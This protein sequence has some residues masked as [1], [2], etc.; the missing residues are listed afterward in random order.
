MTS[1]V[2]AP[3]PATLYRRGMMAT[4]MTLTTERNRPVGEQLRAWRERRRLSQMALALDAEVS[5]RHLS[6]LETGK[7]RPSR[8]ML[9]RLAEHLAVPLRDRNALLLAAG[10]APAYPER[11]LD[12]P[13]LAAAREAVA[14]VLA[15]H[16]PYPALAIDREWTLIAANRAVAPLIERVAPALLRPP[17]NVL[18]L[19][20]HPEG[21]A[22]RTV[23]LREWREHLL[24]RL[25]RQIAVSADAG[26]A[27]LLEELRA[28]PAPKGI[29]ASEEEPSVMAGIAVPFQL[30][31]EQGVLGFLSTT[32]VFGTP[33]DVTL[34]ELAIEAFFPIDARTAEAMREIAGDATS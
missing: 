3:R 1:E 24:T 8:E 4:T 34:S 7:A 17:V 5:T 26:L 29:A 14:R 10:Y 27:R 23:N 2:I 15:G 12:D 28:Y 31:T 18:R 21:L 9:L 6:F 25:E 33:V 20:L 11:P 16:E 32:M 30:R 19:S 22:P 13:A